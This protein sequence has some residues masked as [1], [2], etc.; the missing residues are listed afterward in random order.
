MIK[1]FYFKREDSR[2]IDDLMWRLGNKAVGMM[3]YEKNKNE[4]INSILE[5]F[6]SDGYELVA[7]VD[8]SDLEIAYA[9]LQNG[10]HTESWDKE[11]TKIVKPII[12]T[13]TFN[14]KVYGN[15]SSMM[16]D[17]YQTD[18]GALHIVSAIGFKQIKEGEHV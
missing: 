8:S 13:L 4:I 1:V 6:N 10:V 17:I 14:N 15:R 11:P 7:E 12:G 5:K 18:D 9:H 2:Y 3:D 16:G